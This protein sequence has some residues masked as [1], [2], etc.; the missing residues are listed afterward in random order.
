MT[1]LEFMKE[2]ESLL[3]DIPSE[4]R[5]EALS[6]YNGYFDDAGEDREEEIAKE[7]GS[8]SKV[9]ATIKADLNLNEADREIKGY[10]TEKGY[11]ETIDSEYE[12]VSSAKKATDNSESNNYNYVGSNGNYTNNSYSNNT[13]SNSKYENPNT[14]RSAYGNSKKRQ[15]SSDSILYIIIGI[16]TFPIWFPIVVTVLSIAVGIIATL[17]G[18]IF[19]FGVA[20]VAMIGAGLVLFV[21]GLAEMAVPF[22]GLLMTGGGLI[23]FGLGMLITTAVAFVCK[24]VLP[25]IVMGFVNLCRLPFKNRRVMA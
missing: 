1:K 5:E 20:G 4:E 9:A 13:N 17:L 25:V 2:L 24:N 19:G 15:N 11:Q 16:L 14:N 8:P 12:V 23:V 22:T 6:F 21:A 18:V 7:L 3:P 10:F